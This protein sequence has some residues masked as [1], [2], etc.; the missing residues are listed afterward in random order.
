MSA[1]VSGVIGW[2]ASDLR[3]ALNSAATLENIHRVR[4]NQPVK[5]ERRDIRPW[6]HH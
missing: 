5:I 1:G 4:W 2:N 3:E 6:H